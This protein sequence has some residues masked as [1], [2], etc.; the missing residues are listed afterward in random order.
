MK[1][2]AKIGTAVATT[3]AMASSYA[4]ELTLP[5]DLE[6]TFTSVQTAITTVGGLIISL[7][8]VAMGIKW[9]K[10]TFFG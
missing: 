4:A 6:A 3:T 2:L 8:A 9:V 10:A 7:A 1:L 5:T